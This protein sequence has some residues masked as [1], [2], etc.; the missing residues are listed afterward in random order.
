MQKNAVVVGRQAWRVLQKALVDHGSQYLTIEEIIE[1]ALGKRAITGEFNFGKMVRAWVENWYSWGVLSSIV[2]ACEKDA[3][4]I[5][6]DHRKSKMPEKPR[7]EW[8]RDPRHPPFKW[9]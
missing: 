4:R 1:S 6:E 2:D 3:Y 7:R 9:K 5:K 8:L